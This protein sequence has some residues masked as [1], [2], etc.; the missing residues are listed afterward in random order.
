MQD[1]CEIQ[2]FA[3]C[4][5]RTFHK[6]HELP[7]YSEENNARRIATITKYIVAARVSFRIAGQTSSSRSNLLVPYE[8][9]C[10][11]EYRCAKWKPYLFWFE[12][13]SQGSSLLFQ[14]RSNV[15]VKVT[16]KKIWYHVKGLATRNTNFQYKF[17]TSSGLKVVTKVKVFQK[18]TNLKVKAKKNMV[19]RG[20]SCHKKYTC[21]I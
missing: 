11:K 4:L 18:Y 8:R 15:K 9:S 21:L 20:R 1:F 14:S 5:K 7:S 17:P 13:Y 2:A 3:T 19:P 10:H 12:S 6:D 16:R